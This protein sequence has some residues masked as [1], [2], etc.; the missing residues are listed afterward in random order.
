MLTDGAESFGNKLKSEGKV[1]SKVEASLYLKV[2]LSQRLKQI[3]LGK[4]I[5]W[6]GRCGDI[7]IG[8]KRLNEKNHSKG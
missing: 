2:K 1:K 7:F 4:L 5:Y 3:Y 6:N 8:K